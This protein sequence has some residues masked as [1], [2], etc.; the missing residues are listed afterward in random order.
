M[1]LALGGIALIAAAWTASAMAATC[2]IT[3]ARVLVPDGGF[4]VALP[5]MVGYAIPTEV[6]ES[7]GAFQMDFSGVP[8]GNFNI[9][10]DNSISLA[11]AGV[12]TGTLD[13]NGN[14]ALPPITVD[15]RTALTPETLHTTEF[16][17]TGIASVTL[18]GNDYATIGIPLDFGSGMLRMQG[19]G[20]VFN[21]PVVGTSTTGVLLDCTLTPIPSQDNLPDGPRLTVR[22]TAKPGKPGEAGTVVGDNLTV[23]AK[24]KNGAAT[25]DLTQDVF[26]RIAVGETEAV[27]VRVPGGSLTKSGKKFTASDTDGSVVH[28][29]SGRKTEGSTKAALAGSLVAV[30]SKKG[31]TL[32]LKQSGIDMAPLAA[33][34]AATATVSIGGFTASDAVTLKPGAKKTVLK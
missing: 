14:I 9:V 15:F 24:I 5:D 26:V 30:Q 8:V 3:Q 32:T 12:V 31:V 22:G 4:D 16:L 2:T 28:L 23:K 20:I 27:L 33:G 6:T 29:L 17:T 13:S 7:S 11:P 1:R 19:S 21:A 18:S 34:G 10:V 25:A